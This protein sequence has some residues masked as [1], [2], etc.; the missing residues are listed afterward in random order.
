M[1]LAEICVQ[2]AAI[3]WQILWGPELVTKSPLPFLFLQVGIRITTT[4]TCAWV[5]L[6]VQFHY[7]QFDSPERRITNYVPLTFAC[8]SSGLK[9]AIICGSMVFRIT[10]LPH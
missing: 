6:S 7:Y 9:N 2:N 8:Y 5:R 4:F 1:I 3:L 10:Q